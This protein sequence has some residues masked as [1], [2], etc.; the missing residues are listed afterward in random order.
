MI[1]VGDR[2]KSKS[3]GYYIIVEKIKGGYCKVKFDTG[4]ETITDSRSA[5]NGNVKDPLHPQVLGVGYLGIGPYVS[6]LGP[7]SRGYNNLP[8]YNVWIN[9]IQRCYYD[10]YASR[11]AGVQTYNNNII[12]HE[13]WHNFQN[14][15]MWYVPRRKVFDVAGIKRPALD[16]DIL[17]RFEIKIYS[18]DTC[19]VVPQEI[20]CAILNTHKQTSGIVQGKNGYYIVHKS[21]RVSEYLNTIDEAKS[22]RK[23]V[24][25]EYLVDLAN[26]YKHVLEDRVYD[27]LC[28]WFS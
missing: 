15:A 11:V 27:R 13:D 8:E 5:K 26:K 4:Y 18:P 1:Q 20:N 2:V 14:F 23:Q 28:N 19:C 17:S 16:K 6:S 12:V 10:K 3:C 7:H 24:K 22:M 25:Q 9:M 21:K